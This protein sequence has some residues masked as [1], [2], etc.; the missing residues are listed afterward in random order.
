MKGVRLLF[1]WV[2][3]EEADLQPTMDFPTI[4]HDMRWTVPLY[5]GAVVQPGHVAAGAGRVHGGHRERGGGGVLGGAAAAGAA[6][7]AGRLPGP[8]GDARD[9]DISFSVAAVMS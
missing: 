9:A 6:A 1:R 2:V 8:R 3:V 5:A 4:H 7:Q